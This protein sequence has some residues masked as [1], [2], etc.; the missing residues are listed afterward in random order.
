MIYML[1]TVLLLVGLFGVISQ[2]NLVKIIISISIMESAVNL[3]LVLVGY[4]RNGIAPIMT[5]R[6]QTPVDFAGRSVD[7]LPQAMVLT[8]IVIGLGVMALLVTMALRVYHVYGSYDI[9]EIFKSG[10]RKHE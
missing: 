5:E 1:C 2:R 10:D 4:R 8:S 9:G 6:F 7:P 3:F